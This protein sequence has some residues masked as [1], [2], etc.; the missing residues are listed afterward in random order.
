MNKTKAEE[1][2]K[3]YNDRRV[4]I[5]EATRSQYGGRALDWIFN[6]P[7]FQ[8]SDFARNVNIPMPTARRILRILRECGM[9]REIREA[10]G[11]RA[12]I[13]AFTE[14]LNIAEGQKVF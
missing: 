10:S 6:K 13:L 9:L 5:I 11:R 14:L 12:A 3:L 4:W 8:A 2:L 1:I 7:I